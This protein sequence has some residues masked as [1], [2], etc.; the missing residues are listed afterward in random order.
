[1][2]GPTSYIPP[3]ALQQPQDGLSGLSPWAAPPPS[4]ASPTAAPD[5]VGATPAELPPQAP[6]ELGTA[7]LQ[8]PEQP[9]QPQAPAGLLPGQSAS[10]NVS[11]SGYKPQTKPDRDPMAPLQRAETEV[12][13]HTDA[14]AA[15]IQRMGALQA[16]YDEQV[17]APALAE[18]ARLI[19]QG[20][21]DRQAMNAQLDSERQAQEQRITDTINSIPTTDPNRWWNDR[22]SGQ[23]AASYIAAAID[24]YLNPG[25]KNGALELAGK[26]A[27]RDAAAQAEDNA[28]ARARV[29]YQVS[30]YERLLGAHNLKRQDYL[31]GK[32]Y[33]LEALA[34][35]TEQRGMSFKSP[36]TQQQHQ[37]QADQFRASRDETLVTLANHTA[38]ALG[39]AADR[40]QRERQFK[41][42]MAASKDAAK[43]A[44]DA[45][46][47]KNAPLA[48][49]NSTGFET[50]SADGKPNSIQFAND[51]HGRKQFE[52]L[53]TTGLG[54]T[55]LY[56]AYDDLSRL[57]LG[58]LA[59]MTPNQRTRILAAVAEVKLDAS[60]AAGE[61]L[62]RMTDK[63]MELFESA[64]LAGNPAAL[65]RI[66]SESVFK[67]KIAG[68]KVKIQDD[69]NRL[70]QSNNDRGA[71]WTPPP[72]EGPPEEVGVPT[73]EGS[74][75]N[76]EMSNGM[77]DDPNAYA[78]EGA[79]AA[80]AFQRKDLTSPASGP[81]T[82]RTANEQVNTVIEELRAGKMHPDLGRTFVGTLGREINQLRA[83]GNRKEADALS[84]KLI[85]LLMATEQAERNRKRDTPYGDV[86]QAQADTLEAQRQH[87]LNAPPMG[88][89]GNTP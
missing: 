47:G 18:K 63:D 29:G 80:L 64:L 3:W 48:L 5:A 72:V 44:A 71:H 66:A 33:R 40:A 60:S 34:V 43:A 39:Q 76:E 57:D 38:T 37:L 11:Y 81:D 42:Q 68:S 6:W 35:Q 85:D 36:I 22:N 75:S 58:K 74:Q 25:G 8:Q 45:D 65:K 56:R 87:E 61:K 19:E 82:V 16:Q 4:T 52:K 32:A 21:H 1:M 89:Y 7:A 55:K 54:A 88:L 86:T 14:V 50:K 70:A 69:M 17:T 23:H 26:L 27:D 59:S 79:A 84:G 62:G 78:G 53:Q 2:A 46:A 9:A 51:E 49:G 77:Y 28:T 13:G 41:L 31:E 24:G 20:E 12:R 83:A 10:A 67:E 15:D 30:A 73:L